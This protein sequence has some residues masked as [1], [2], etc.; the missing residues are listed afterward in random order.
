VDITR[1]YGSIVE[2]ADN[3]HDMTAGSIMVY[4]LS[5]HPTQYSIVGNLNISDEELNMLN[6]IWGYESFGDPKPLFGVRTTNGV[7]FTTYVPDQ[8]TTTLQSVKKTLPINHKLDEDKIEDSNHL[9]SL[10]REERQVEYNTIPKM[11]QLLLKKTLNHRA[12]KTYI[13]WNNY[14]RKIPVDHTK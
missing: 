5:I 11:W 12:T 14:L 8:S 6:F 9:G 10:N 3:I 4:L 7:E 13:K 2:G 1:K